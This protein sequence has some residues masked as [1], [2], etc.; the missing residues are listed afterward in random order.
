VPRT[1]EV[2]LRQLY[3]T[4]GLWSRAPRARLNPAGNEPITRSWTGSENQFSRRT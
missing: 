2:H 1:V 3:R 4:L